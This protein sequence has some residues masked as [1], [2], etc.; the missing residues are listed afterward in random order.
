[1]D[2]GDVIGHGLEITG[3]FA[4]AAIGW[5]TRNHDKQIEAQIK[6]MEALENHV[7]DGVNMHMQ[8]K[9]TFHTYTL[10]SEKRFAKEETLQ[11]SLGRV[12]N[13]LDDLYEK[14]DQNFRELMKAVKP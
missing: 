13:R 12:H 9:D 1:M 10:D 8:L 2:M 11:A 4:L 7:R 5:F 3:T 14:I 6:R